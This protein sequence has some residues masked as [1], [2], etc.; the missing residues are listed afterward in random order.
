MAHI[1]N[2]RKVFNWSI[3]LVTGEF[4]PWLAQKVDL[5]D[6]EIEVVEHGDSNHSIKTPGR[7]SYS[8]IVIDK[9]MLSSGA[10]NFMWGWIDQC[11]SS[12]IGGGAVPD[13]LKNSINIFEL[14]E[15]G[16]TIINT[17]LAI[18]VWPAKVN[19]HTL[20]RLASENSIEVLELS[21]DKL[22]KV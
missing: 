21:V 3:E 6:T 15:D 22:S 18:G 9:L 2:P 19:G 16:N 10:D 7:V 5:P 8:N 17:W 1:T 4:D 12:I 11:Q 20:D 14:A 13:V